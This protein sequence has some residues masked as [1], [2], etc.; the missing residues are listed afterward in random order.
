MESYTLKL[1]TFQTALENVMRTVLYGYIF[2]SLARLVSFFELYHPVR[3]ILCKNCIVLLHSN[4]SVQ[5][6]RACK[7]VAFSPQSL[8]VVQ[9]LFYGRLLQLKYR[10]GLES[11]HR[12]KNVQLFPDTMIYGTEFHCQGK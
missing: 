10:L 2:C 8:C 9:Y 4:V 6:W 11:A 12:D 5:T 7:V 3:R 1:F